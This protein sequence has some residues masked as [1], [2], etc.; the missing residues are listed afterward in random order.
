M[1][2][3]IVLTPP[4]YPRD[5]RH[6]EFD[7]SGTGISYNVGDCLGVYPH[8]NP[9]EVCIISKDD[10][11]DNRSERR[12]RQG[13]IDWHISYKVTVQSLNPPQSNP[14]LFI[15]SPAY[16]KLSVTVNAGYYECNVVVVDINR[17]Y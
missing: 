14:N 2:K 6:Y 12:R 16:T 9:D 10:G 1:T 11:L 4:D 13:D 8:N 5:I 7:L 15:H 3:N 17:H